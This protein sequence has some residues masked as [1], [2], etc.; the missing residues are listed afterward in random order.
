MASIGG[1]RLCGDDETIRRLPT[2]PRLERL[3]VRQHHDFLVELLAALLVLQRAPV[4][5]VNRQ[6]ED[7]AMRDLLVAHDVERDV[8]LARA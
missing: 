4:F 6:L 3:T 8:V 7:A 1:F 5:V 2:E